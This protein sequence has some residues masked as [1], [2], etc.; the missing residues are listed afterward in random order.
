MVSTSLDVQR[1]QVYA[2]LILHLTLRMNLLLSASSK[3]M[4]LL[5]PWIS[6][7]VASRRTGYPTLSWERRLLTFLASHSPTSGQ[8][9]G[10]SMKILVSSVLHSWDKSALVLSPECSAT[11]L[12][13]SILSSRMP[14]SATRPVFPAHR[15][16]GWTFGHGE[17]M[18]AFTVPVLSHVT[19]ILQSGLSVVYS[20][21]LYPTS[22][23]VLASQQSQF[24]CVPFQ[25]PTSTMA[26]DIFAYSSIELLNTARITQNPAL[27]TSSST[28]FSGAYWAFWPRS[29]IESDVGGVFFILAACQA[30]S[31]AALTF[32]VPSIEAAEVEAQPLAKAAQDGDSSSDNPETPESDEVVPEPILEV[33]KKPNPLALVE[34][35]P[36]GKTSASVQETASVESDE[37]LLSDLESALEKLHNHK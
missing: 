6:G 8:E 30:R 12:T 5:R 3:T 21:K 10:S 34:S 11:T 17:R 33:L 32:S 9:T 27:P 31:E 29:Q 35:V 19:L 24:E 23:S 37:Q 36:A 7:L 26:T 1:G 2:Y 18:S 14:S 25:C 22:A 28:G 16:L 4:V 13:A 15:F 20:S